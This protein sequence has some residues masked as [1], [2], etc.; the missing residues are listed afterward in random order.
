MHTHI[1]CLC[2]LLT[3][4]V[5][6][7]AAQDPGF[8]WARSLGTIMSIERCIDD[9]D[10]RAI[11]VGMFSGTRDLDLG[12]AE[13]IITPGASGNTGF[14]TAI[15]ANGTMDWARAIGGTQSTNIYDVCVANDGSI[16][17]T[18]A[19]R[20]TVDLNPSSTEEFPAI[21][22]GT[23]DV[24][25]V[26]LS[27]DGDFLWGFDLGNTYD[28]VTARITLDASGNL[29]MAMRV[30]GN[31]DIDPGPATVTVAGGADGVG[32]IA[33]Y[34]PD[35]TYQWHRVMGPT[36]HTLAVLAN[37]DI[38]TG[39]S[40]SGMAVIGEEPNTITVGSAGAG[41]MHAYVR[42]NAQAH[43][44]QVVTFQGPN[45]FK[46]HVAPDGSL[47]LAGNYTNSID[48]DP[49]PGTNIHTPNGIMDAFALQLNAQWEAKWGHTWGDEYSD[50]LQDFDV[51][52][53]GNVYI[54][55]PLYFSLDV[56][57][58]PG[59][60]LLDAGSSTNAYLLIFDAADGAVRSAARLLNSDLGHIS[61]GGVHVTSNGT[62]LSH[63]KF[64][65]TA[66]L[67][68]WT[69]TISLTVQTE[70]SEEAYLC[71][72]TQEIGLA[73]PAIAAD[74]PPVLFPVPCTER[75]FV[76]TLDRPA[77]YQVLDAAGRMV[78]A[79]SLATGIA[80]LDVSRLPSGAYHLRLHDDRTS[81]TLRF[82]KE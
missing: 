79:G 58:G 27:A 72:F 5:P 76:G 67:D 28:E 16:I 61:T 65:A 37:G 44:Q 43:P 1:L 48:L 62:I 46:S 32:V 71:S 10:G 53:Y 74:D 26:K 68:P 2:V 33:K 34:D 38:V 45:Q 39:H 66:A 19:F 42:S 6:P 3:T 75:L 55:A 29:F 70:L 64:R 9:P 57:P 25:F 47:T 56:D 60:I 8:G 40:F 21:A 7:A 52:G 36:P 78:Q 11:A 4:A 41:T 24:F 13:H 30:R 80:P 54:T 81:R 59:E 35:G 14:I 50:Q 73:T 17:V 51:D 63:G 31:M 69:N 22:N 49:G 20:G 82:V 18:G 12:P 23:W 77:R 15:Q